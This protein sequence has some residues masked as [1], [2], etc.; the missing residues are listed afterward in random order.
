MIR[1]FFP[2]RINSAVGWK[3]ILGVAY[4]RRVRLGSLTGD[5]ICCKKTKKSLHWL[6]LM[7][8]LQNIENQTLNIYLTICFI[9]V[10]EFQN[11]IPPLSL[12][13]GGNFI[14]HLQVWWDGPLNLPLPRPQ[15]PSIF[16][17]PGD[18]E[19]DVLADSDGQFSSV[20]TKQNFK[21]TQIP[22]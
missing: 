2:D 22:K 20:L 13:F 15:R 9:E 16:C 21:G 11:H 4:F 17:A 10:L 5:Q 8:C 3:W 19:V 6:Q 18:A 14:K 7:L 12:E 1:P